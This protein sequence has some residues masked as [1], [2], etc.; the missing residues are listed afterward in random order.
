MQGSELLFKYQI[1]DCKPFTV[2]ND[3]LTVIMESESN[4][5]NNKEENQPESPDGLSELDYI[6][7]SIELP[8]NEALKLSIEAI[9][10]PKPQLAGE[11]G[12]IR[13]EVSIKAEEAREPTTIEVGP[14]GTWRGDSMD[15][16]TAQSKP[17]PQPLLSRTLIL[18]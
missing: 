1:S 15:R 2:N 10:Q 16:L 13:Y 9:P 14:S 5:P 11:A 17:V 7:I 6:H 4:H 8:E 3:L 12:Q 18:A